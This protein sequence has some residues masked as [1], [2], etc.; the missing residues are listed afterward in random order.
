MMSKTIKYGFILKKKK[1]AA[2]GGQSVSSE[3]TV[4]KT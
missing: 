4:K 3:H 1:S 2:A